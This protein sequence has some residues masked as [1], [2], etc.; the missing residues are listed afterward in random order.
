MSE[1]ILVLGGGAWGTAVAS[2]LATNGFS[3][4]MWCFEDSVV[5]DIISCRM[6]KKYFDGHVLDENIEVTA[7]LSDAFADTKIVFVAV[8]VKFLHDTILSAKSYIKKDHEWVI[9]SKGIFFGG[10]PQ[11]PSD[12]LSNLLSFSPKM[13]VLS[14]PNFADQVFEKEFTQTV[15]AS[16]DEVFG[17]KICS[18][19]K[20]DYFYPIF[21]DD[22]IGVQVGGALKN[23]ISFF[24][25]VLKGAGYKENTIAAFLIAGIKEMSRFA[26]IHGGQEKT[27]YGLAGVGDL[28]L[29]LIGKKNRNFHAGELIGRGET[30]SDISQNMS[31]L[32]EGFN[33]IKTVY[34]MGEPMP[35]CEG[36]YKIVF[37]GA[38]VKGVVSQLQEKI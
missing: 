14:G 6:N 12:V 11:F 17:K 29:G 20:N 18:L 22:F 21:S 32:P 19:C 3:V 33:T 34:K 15:V 16:Q 23:V 26:T 8:P 30:M 38:S 5:E 7:S 1:K 27:I 4:K 10:V 36:L 13:A 31:A 24:L 25:G 35:I 9:L 28:M 2:L 37:E